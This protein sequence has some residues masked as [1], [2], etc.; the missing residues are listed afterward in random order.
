MD[1]IK[2]KM[3]LLN[4]TTQVGDCQIWWGAINNSGK[5]Y[6]HT[7]INRKHWQM[8]R[9]SYVLNK[10]PIPEGLCVLHTCDIR[11]CV[12]PEHLF[13]G[14]K[15]DNSADARAKGRLNGYLNLSNISKN[16]H[17]GRVLT[18]DQVCEIREKYAK[19]GHTNR[20]LAKEY[21][22]GKSAIGYIIQGK[23]WKP[24]SPFIPKKH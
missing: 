12:N 3:M 5:G 14:T 18:Y 6:G 13:L 19:G 24:N 10:G 9:L 21:G 7:L 4:R 22:I 11:R 8:H 23:N 1:K 17:R 15:L 16:G 2:L 20:S